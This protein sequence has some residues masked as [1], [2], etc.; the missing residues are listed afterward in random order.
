M[1]DQYLANQNLA[2]QIPNQNQS[3]S[4]N[5]SHQIGIPCY[6]VSDWVQSYHGYYEKLT[7]PLYRLQVPKARVRLVL[8]FGDRLQITAIHAPIDSSTYQSFVVGLDAAPLVTEHHGSRGCMTIAMLPWVAHQLFRGAS[9]ELASETIALEDFWG[10]EALLLGEQLS[11]LSSWRARFTRV[12]QVLVEKFNTSSQVVRPEIQLA[13]NQLEAWKGCISIRQLAKNLGWSDRH[14][15]K[16]FREYIGI[17]PKAAARQIR[18]A[19]AHQLLIAS[20]QN[21]LSQIAAACGYSD[22]SHFTR[23]FHWFSGYSPHTYQ[24]IYD[25]SF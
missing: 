24:N 19:Y 17:T 20:D 16:C 11:E 23:E 6:P 3:D 8:G 25:V 21:A 22:Q 12:D 9:T 10:K 14:F 4:S 13:W 1:K 15:A 7:Q 18:F 2:N 5:W